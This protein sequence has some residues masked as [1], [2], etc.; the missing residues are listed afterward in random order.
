MTN[1]NTPTIG[2]NTKKQRY[3]ITYK[4]Q[5]VVGEKYSTLLMELLNSSSVHDI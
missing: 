2:K 1:D 5:Q 3:A 4:E